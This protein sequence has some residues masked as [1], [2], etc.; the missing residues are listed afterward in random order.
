MLQ[1][2]ICEGVFTRQA[3]CEHAMVRCLHT[4]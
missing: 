3:S 2:L 4:R 1:C